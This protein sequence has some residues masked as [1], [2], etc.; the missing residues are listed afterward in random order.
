[1]SLRRPTAEGPIEKLSEVRPA[2]EPFDFAQDR[3][4]IKFVEKKNLPATT[5]GQANFQFPA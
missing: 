3:Q 2:V 1:M 4:A 5:P